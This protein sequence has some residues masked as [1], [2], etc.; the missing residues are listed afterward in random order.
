VRILLAEDNEINQQIAVEL[1]EGA[2][3]RVDVAANGR[4]ALERL[5]AAPPGTYALVLM[6]VQMPEMDGIEATHQIRA[7]ARHAKLPVIAMTAH[8]MAEERKRCAAAG[9]NDHISKPIEPTVMFQTLARWLGGKAGPVA[10]ATIA[11]D[12]HLPEVSGLDAADGLRRV[13]GNRRL[14][15]DLLRQF[16]HKQTDAAARVAA[17]LRKKDFG[18]A[19]RIAHSVKGVAGNL[20]I[21]GLYLLADALEKAV[22]SR[23]AVKAALSAFEAELARTTTA[24]KEVVAPAAAPA[25][26]ADAGGGARH[27]ANLASMLETSNAEATDY[28]DAHQAAIRAM[29]PNG[30]SAAFEKAL[31]EFDFEVALQELR[32]ASGGRGTTLQGETA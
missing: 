24:L 12:E 31:G 19:E 14:Y 28:F 21:R 32:R 20:G 29:F 22:R 6:D 3:A 25:P 10:A 11:D 26:P 5:G 9:M 18:A 17:A 27:A 16:A 7:D 2:G 4:E 8:A 23:E 30:G 1:L 13:G 15:R